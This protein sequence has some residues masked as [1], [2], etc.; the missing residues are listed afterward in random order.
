METG[1]ARETETTT[2]P[3]GRR[4]M[5]MMMMRRRRRRRKMVMDYYSM[6]YNQCNI[7]DDGREGETE[8]E[9][10]RIV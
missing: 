9:G 8:R 6:D 2:S 10:N 1:E 4:M 7:T 3:V 5:M